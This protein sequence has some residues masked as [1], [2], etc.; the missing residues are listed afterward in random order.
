MF[1]DVDLGVAASQ[2]RAPGDRASMIA[3]GG[4]G[5]RHLA[6]IGPLC[7]LLTDQIGHRIGTS[8]C[9]E[10]TEAK[11]CRLILVDNT[12]HP[13]M[14]SN[15]RQVYK[16]CWCIAGPFADGV[17]SPAHIGVVEQMRRIG[18]CLAGMRS[19]RNKTGVD[20]AS[21]SGCDM[22]VISHYRGS[23]EFSLLCRPGIEDF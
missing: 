1:M 3:I 15:F 11:P 22:R 2:L 12:C 10:G 14:G 8:Q 9:L 18:K 13:A 6:N 16:R 7:H 4:S 5:Y 17:K 23:L 21:L 20:M 19:V